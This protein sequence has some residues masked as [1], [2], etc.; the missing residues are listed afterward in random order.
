MNPLKRTETSSVFDEAASIKKSKQDGVKPPLPKELTKLFQPL[1]CALCK[2]QFSSPVTAASH[3]SGKGHQKKIKQ[4]LTQNNP[5]LL[6]AEETTASKKQEAR[7]EQILTSLTPDQASSCR[8]CDV[9]FAGPVAAQSHYMG[10]KHRT[11]VLKGYTPIERVPG[12]DVGV[13]AS[14]RFGIGEGFRKQEEPTSKP[15]VPVVKRTIQKLYCDICDTQATDESQY[16]AHIAGKKHIKNVNKLKL[17]NPTA[18][19][20]N[21]VN[22]KDTVLNSVLKPGKELDYST[23]RTPSGSY[24]CKICDL[25]VNS[26]NQF[27]DHLVS[28]KHKKKKASSTSSD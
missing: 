16:K 21:P 13:D 20:I 28:K 11:N 26:V 5:E 2:S 22:S 4:Y 15:N 1:F 25:T 19:L 3:Y 8:I 24:Y 27:S 9:M 12:M 17:V 18:T 10:K 14:G 7:S 6:P 23:H